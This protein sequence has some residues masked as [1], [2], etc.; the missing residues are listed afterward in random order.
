MNNKEADFGADKIFNKD[1]EYI[2][3]NEPV[4]IKPVKLYKTYELNEEGLRLYGKYKKQQ[5]LSV[6]KWSLL[7]TSIGCLFSAIV[8]ISFKKMTFK[9]KDF[10]KTFVLLGSITIFSYCGIQA[11]TL[12]FRAK[13]KEL[14]SMYGK[15]VEEES[16]KD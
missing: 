2:K 10:F 13:Q 3:T 14:S 8:D 16:D 7:G 1:L 12:Q 5:F 15:E 11:S 9:S 6:I 4:E